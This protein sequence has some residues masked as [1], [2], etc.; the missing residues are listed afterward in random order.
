MIS[1]NI[2]F[3]FAYF[4]TFFFGIFH[5]QTTFYNIPILDNN[6]KFYYYI[7]PI[8][9][10]LAIVFYKSVIYPRINRTKFELKIASTAATP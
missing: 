2:Y 9:Y 5:D 8:V 4:V 6:E 3:F 10:V 7:I 1:L